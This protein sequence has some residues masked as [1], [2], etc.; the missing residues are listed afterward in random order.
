MVVPSKSS[1]LIGISISNHS[2]WGTPIYGN[3]HIQ[4]TGFRTAWYRR[5]LSGFT[6]CACFWPEIL[7]GKLVCTKD[8][9]SIFHL[10][11]PTEAKSSAV[12]GGG[13]VLVAL[14]LQHLKLRP[15][16][17]RQQLQ[18]TLQSTGSKHVAI[19]GR[20]WIGEVMA[21]NPIP[22]KWVHRLHTKIVASMQRMTDQLCPVPRFQPHDC[23]RTI[24]IVVS[25][26]PVT[27]N[28]G[29]GHQYIQRSYVAAE[30]MLWGI[31]S[32]PQ[33]NKPGLI[34]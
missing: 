15:Q 12:D 6:H 5:G 17:L 24:P 31:N 7:T 23:W 28:T 26:L 4:Y 19:N 30:L 2:F 18:T 13:M 21:P 25:L 34:I 20:P 22:G 9:G 27:R 29:I 11:F 10:F 8:S 3:L 14:Y 32:Q 16:V 33:M 1:I